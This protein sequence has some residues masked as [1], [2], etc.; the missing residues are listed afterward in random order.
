M[1]LKLVR[2]PQCGQTVEYHAENVSRPFCS[3]RC[4]L[5]DLGA[6]A[7]D[8]YAIAA[9]SSDAVISGMTVDTA[10]LD[11]TPAPKEVGSE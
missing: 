1:K 5:L 7:E 10:F 4:K 3:P 6:W 8:R 9:S 2:C 11:P